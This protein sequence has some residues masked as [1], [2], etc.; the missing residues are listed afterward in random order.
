MR[1]RSAL[2]PDTNLNPGLL[3]HPMVLG[4]TA[5]CGRHGIVGSGDDQAAR[6]RAWLS[7]VIIKAHAVGVLLWANNAEGAQRGFYLCISQ[8]PCPRCALAGA[9]P[10]APWGHA[11]ALHTSPGSTRPRSSRSSAP[12]AGGAAINAHRNAAN[13]L[14]RLKFYFETRAKIS[15]LFLFFFFF[16]FFR[17]RC[18]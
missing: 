5:N 11:L 2:Q 7:H 18:M 15:G 1:A 13:T 6:Y 12:A 8:D 3:S 17:R 9:E 10:T 14:P 16:L 4:S